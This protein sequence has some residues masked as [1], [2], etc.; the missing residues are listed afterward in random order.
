MRSHGVLGMGGAARGAVKA[1]V[2]CEDAGGTGKLG[3]ADGE[4]GRVPADQVDAL[5]ARYQNHYGQR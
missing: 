1:A 4:V 5:Y 3:R 2:R